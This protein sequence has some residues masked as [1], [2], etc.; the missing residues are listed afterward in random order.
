MEAV[1][2]L[3]GGIAHDF[4]N[5]LTV[6]N[7][8]SRLMFERMPE[9]DDNREALAEIM[10]S[11]ERAANLTRQL[12]A[13][14]RK[15]RL[16]PQIV[17]VNPLLEGLTKL[18]RALIGEDIALTFTPDEQLG[19][20]RLD[21]A[22]FEQ[23]IINLAVNARDAM[24]GGGHVT[25]D[26]HER[27]LDEI[28]A[29]SNPEV[30]P[31]RYVC[32]AV[33]DS[34]VGM[35]EATKARIFEPFFTTKEP[36]K[37]TGLGLAM[38]YGFV[39]QSGG[40]IDVRSAPNAGT[41]FKIYL[42]VEAHGDSTPIENRAPSAIPKGTETVLLV[43]DESA[44][45]SLLRAVLQSNGYQVIEAADGESGA[46]RAASYD[47][48]IDLLLTDV[49]MPKLG[50]RQLAELLRRTR[51]NIRVLFMS[52]Y[53]DQPIDD[54]RGGVDAFLQ[55]PFSPVELT[56]KLREILDRPR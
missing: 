53:T 35:D 1:G 54:D 45:R 2:R 34:G 29:Q 48:H 4:N 18:L 31:G 22:Q 25:L 38:V 20:V 3:A 7:G 17:N 5:I 44:V 10:Q 26:T 9:G 28:Y 47:A 43:E 24:P 37:G 14:S 16:R 23:A 30:R 19:A 6:I 49:V 11:G 8:F 39:K 51:P 40:H 52:G 50:G 55:K 41:S 12:L 42:P 33:T 21:P 56:R 32:V 15:Q 13:F 46:A 36:G 27:D